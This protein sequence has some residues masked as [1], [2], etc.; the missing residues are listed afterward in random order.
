MFERKNMANKDNTKHSSAGSM[1]GSSD[2]EFEGQGKKKNAGMG[3]QPGQTS[4]SISKKGTG[5]NPGIEED[6]M[7]T[8]GGRQ[9]NFSDKNRG[10]E[11]QWSPGSSGASDQ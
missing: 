9:G 4:D 7:N 3:G 5:S 11:D 8:A 2:R 6:E 10:R 1:S